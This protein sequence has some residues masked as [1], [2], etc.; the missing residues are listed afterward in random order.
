M[1]PGNWLAVLPD[2]EGLFRCAECVSILRPF[3]WC[4]LSIRVTFD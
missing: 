4:M 1:S 2:A 3:V